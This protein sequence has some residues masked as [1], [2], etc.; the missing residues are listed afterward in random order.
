MGM[1]YSKGK[2]AIGSNSIAKDK[3]HRKW[4][5]ITMIVE[6]RKTNIVKC[7]NIEIDGEYI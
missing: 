3:K 5:K 4:L 7:K 1:M 6:D 2:L